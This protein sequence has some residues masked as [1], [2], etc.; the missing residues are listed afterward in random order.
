MMWIMTFGGRTAVDRKRHW[1][2]VY[3]EK[4]AHETS[5]YQAVPTPSLQMIRH[6]ADGAT[7]SLID[8]GGGA[9]LLADVLLE[10]GFLDLTVLDISARALEQARLRL[11]PRADRIEWIEADVTEFV[12][13]RSW[14][15]WHD[16]AA[17]HF[18][19]D[20]ADRARYVDVLRRALVVG[21]QAIIAAF[22]PD[23]PQRCSGLEI[24]R[25]KA[26]TLAGELGPGFEL[27]EERC[28]VHLT[29]AGSEQRFGFY[30]FRKAG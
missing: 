19:I 4:S 5:W 10:Q 13:G 22:A 29:P 27:E 1:E 25:Y 28:E 21:G 7:P 12:P 16:R 11:G 3:T 26:Q 9:S 23:G 20:P 18:L 14:E 30:R 8:V 6:A 24:V 17:F 15:I 2:R